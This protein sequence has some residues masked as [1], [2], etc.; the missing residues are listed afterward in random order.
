MAI[1][2][3]L[4]LPAAPQRLHVAAACLARNDTPRFWRR[5]AGSGSND[6]S[7][8]RAAEDPLLTSAFLLA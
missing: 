3:R 2:F 7:L 4:A 1:C 8:A 5:A 6:N